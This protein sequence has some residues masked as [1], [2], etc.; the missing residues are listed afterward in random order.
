MLKKVCS[1]SV[2]ACVCVFV[3]IYNIEIYL[4]RKSCNF[5]TLRFMCI[6]RTPLSC[7]RRRFWQCCAGSWSRPW[8]V[9]CAQW[10]YNT[11]LQLCWCRWLSA[12]WRQWRG[13]RM[14][15]LG[16]QT[17]VGDT[18]PCSS[19][20]GSLR[21]RLSTHPT[22]YLWTWCRSLSC[23]TQSHRRH[24]ATSASWSGALSDRP[25]DVPE[26]PQRAGTGCWDHLMSR[27]SPHPP[28]S[29]PPAVAGADHHPRR[30]AECGWW[31]RYASYSPGPPTSSPS[32]RCDSCPTSHRLRKWRLWQR[33]GSLDKGL[34]RIGRKSIE[35]TGGPGYS[36]RVPAETGR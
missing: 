18:D 19:S 13:M 26:P 28:R 31:G 12:G 1:T 33:G 17:D 30:S 32:P 2:C 23:S 34:W 24:N 29:W 14:L 15:F 5:H 35:K 25:G 22:G 7:Q 16:S 8:R 11:N 20:Y 4:K 3:N 9:A 21:V 10:E 6:H 27:G 36:G